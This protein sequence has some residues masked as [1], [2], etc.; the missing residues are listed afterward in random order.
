MSSKIDM[1]QSL[2]TEHSTD[3]SRPLGSAGTAEAVV[4]TRE[5]TSP[6]DRRSF[7][8]IAGLGVGTLAVVGAGGLTWR[9]VDGGVFATGTGPAYAAWNESSPSGQ[10]A[11]GMVRAAVLAA[12][13]HNTQPW[14]FKVATN[15]IDLFADSSRNIGTM[16]PLGR[17]MHISLGCAIENLVLAGPANGKA[18]TVTL[19]PDPTDATHIARVDLVPRH[20][21]ASALF[22]AIPIRHTNRAAYDTRQPVAQ[23]QLDALGSLV[24]APDTELV[25]FNA[26][27]DKRAF[28][29]LTIR[30]TRAII[31]DP[32]QAADDFAWYRTS[33]QEIQ[34]RKDGIT[35]DPSG[36]S[37]LIRDLAKVLPVSRQQNN[38]G[39]LSG[40][41]GSQI[42]TAAAFGA[43]VVRDPLDPIA[44][45]RVGRIW[46]RIHLAAT[47]NGM[48]MQPLCQVLERID[49]ERSAGLPADFTTAM[50]AMLPARRHAI[51]TFRIGFPTADALRSPRRPAREVV[52]T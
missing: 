25:W 28:G 40:T 50:A 39:W 26:A 12:N 35:I 17:E 18:P 48:G 46:Q 30:A 33:W 52:L 23:R 5:A 1:S 42:P 45:L 43:L 31:A 27:E 6:M 20:R 24:D 36:Q 14:H 29:D 34:A 49:R 21:S 10:D 3:M 8:R 22:A 19:L 47:V 2:G 4:G 38:D 9:A 15:R 51:M 11:L 44:R 32:Q 16:D 37:P 7:L 13:A 41:R